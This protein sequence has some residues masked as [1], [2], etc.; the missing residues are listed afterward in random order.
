[1]SSFLGSDCKSDLFCIYTGIGMPL[2]TIDL[3]GSNKITDE[4]TQNI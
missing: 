1:M 2:E 3:P 4:G